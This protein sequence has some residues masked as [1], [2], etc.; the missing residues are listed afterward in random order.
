LT[1]DQIYEVSRRITSVNDHK[2]KLKQF[3]F[4]RYANIDLTNLGYIRLLHF[5][6]K[7]EHPLTSY[8]IECGMGE[9]KYVHKMLNNLITPSSS[10]EHLFIWDKVGTS[11]GKDNENVKKKIYRILNSIYRLD[12]FRETDMEQYNY[13]TLSSDNKIITLS[14]G[15]DKKLEIQLIK[16]KNEEQ[17]NE[18]EGQAVLNIYD[19]KKRFPYHHTVNDDK[20]SYSGFL[21]T[22]RKGDGLH[23]YVETYYNPL[24]MLRYLDVEYA[25]PKLKKSKK[26]KELISGNFRG[27]LFYL[28]CELN[29]G[30]TNDSERR[31][32]DVIFNPS[33]VK[34]IPFLTY[35]KEF[36]DV[37]FDVLGIL[38]E[39]ISDFNSII[40]EHYKNYS[41]NYN[42]YEEDHSAIIGMNARDTSDDN[43]K[44][45]ITERCHNSLLE[46][47][48]AF[49]CPTILSP[50]VS[51][52]QFF[53]YEN[54]N[55]RGKLNEYNLEML[56]IQR[57]LSIQRLN[58]INE[59]INY[60]LPIYPISF[61]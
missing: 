55:I 54:L 21:M 20:K 61:S 9:S 26:L 53:N 35:W 11:D 60:G 58:R 6:L 24:T 31:I 48:A 39:I 32:Y 7:S 5:I 4:S 56:M 23:V 10:L 36:G 37:G 41:H 57:N 44:L 15:T 2:N 38:R 18:E 16:N 45:I 51:P 49:E 33:L 59:S 30:W 50:D 19:D 3:N 34:K 13:L 29:Y 43:I 42:T 28:A 14:Y 27:F 12:W 52:K 22:I 40:K 8:E 25:S 46:Y 47:F 17:A 1:S